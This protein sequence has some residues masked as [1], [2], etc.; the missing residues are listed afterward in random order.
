MLSQHATIPTL[1]IIDEISSNA[2]FT[3]W[4]LLSNDPSIALN[5]HSYSPLHATIPTTSITG[6]ISSNA[7]FTNG[8]V[9]LNGHPDSNG[10][11]TPKH[12]TM[13]TT[14]IIDEISSSTCLASRGVVLNGHSNSNGYRTLLVL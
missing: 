12:V 9:G 7:C 5:G 3:I 10:Y 14:S 2:C 8:S 11:L 13:L 1:P 4:V 6:K